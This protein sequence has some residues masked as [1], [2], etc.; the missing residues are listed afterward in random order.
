MIE[1]EVYSVADLQN[2][3][4]RN[5]RLTLNGFPVTLAVAGDPIAH[6][7]SPQMHN[8]ALE[9]LQI[10]S[11]YT[12]LRVPSHD[13]SNV[14]SLLPKLDFKGIN[15]TLPHKTH[16]LTLVDE[17]DPHAQLLGA[18]NTIVI[19]NGK[20]HGFNTD[21]PGF[22]QAI[23][24]EFQVDVRELRV[25]VLG[26]GG[27]CGRAIATQCA[28]EGCEKLVIVNRTYDKAASLREHLVKNSR[29]FPAFDPNKQLD[30]IKWRTDLIGEAIDDVD[31]LVNA[32]CFGL[33]S[34]PGV[35]GPILT[36]DNIKPHLMV[37]D[38]IYSP[39]H[40]K[41]QTEAE[42][43]GARAASGESMLLYQGTEAFTKWFKVDAPVSTM[44]SA[45]AEN[46]LRP[47]EKYT[48]ASV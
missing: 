36:R 2:A 42:E 38:T 33:G 4:R 35:Q 25:L 20:L 44:R 40:T 26:A 18:I 47:S 48:V 43:A 21:G 46:G 16:G 15:L 1:K 27:G 3:V 45:L 37:Y 9:E 19:E 12:R 8:A 31:L 41:L 39:Q 29:D 6:P 5:K 13:L 30:V 23:R 14:L 17:V 11:R 34:R 10:P 7:A 32:T 22:V 24:D 28:I